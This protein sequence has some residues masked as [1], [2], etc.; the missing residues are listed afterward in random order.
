MTRMERYRQYR[1]EPPTQPMTAGQYV[2]SELIQLKKELQ[3]LKEDNTYLRDKLDEKEEQLDTIA[4][5]L[6]PFEFEFD[7]ENYFQ[8][9]KSFVRMYGD[10]DLESARFVLDL[11]NQ[12]P[13]APE[14][15][16]R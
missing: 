14:S 8:V 10:N 12:R 5:V 15:S 9:R 2:V 6:K 11:I 7:G 1:E 3:A 13:T 4:R 16:D